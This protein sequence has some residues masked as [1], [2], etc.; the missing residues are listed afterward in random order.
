M[1]PQAQRVRLYTHVERHLGPRERSWTTL[2]D[3]TALPFE[4]CL[5]ADR[6]MRGATTFVT[7]GMSEAV[8]SFPSGRPTRQELVFSTY[9]HHQPSEVPQ[10]LA[11]LGLEAR[12]SQRALARGEVIGPGGALFPETSM[13]ALYCSLPSYLPDEFWGMYDTDPGTLFMWLIP[14]HASEA[15]YVREKGWSSFE[16]LLVQQDPDL[17]DL[18]RPSVE[19]PPPRQGN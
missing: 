15:A 5:V 7:L 10:L 17:M 9:S 13:E 11:G 14:I 1:D 2:A 4:I 8:L 16:D 12:Q 6:P 3:G 19:L 18:R